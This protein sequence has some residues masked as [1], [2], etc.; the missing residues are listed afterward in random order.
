MQTLKKKMEKQIEQT[1]K[2]IV[3]TPWNGSPGENL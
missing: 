1:Q 2:K 3:W